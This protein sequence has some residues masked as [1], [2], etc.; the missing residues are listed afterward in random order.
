MME[1]KKPVV[2]EL[3]NITKNFGDTKVLR[4]ID[5]TVHEG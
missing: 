1:Q 2:L 3:K 4:G 5:L